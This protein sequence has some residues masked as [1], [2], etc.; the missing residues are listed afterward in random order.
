MTA[1]LRHFLLAVQFFTRIPITGRLALWVG[2]SQPMLNASAG[3]F[4]GV[5]W[6]VGVSAALVM[7]LALWLLPAGDLGALTA[8]I[9]STAASV[10]LTG[11]FHED[12]LSDTADGLGGAR[13]RDRALEI[14]KDSRIGNYGALALALALLLK[15]AL[16]AGLAARGS[17]AV[18]CALIAAHVLSR[19]APLVVMRSLPYVGAAQTSKSKPL[20]EAV[21]AASFRAGCLWSLPALVVLWFAHG[22]VHLVFALVLWGVMLFWF[23]RLL[24]RR[25]CGFTGDTLGATQQVCEL[26]LYLGLALA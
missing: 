13:G 18:A 14:M 9:L 26:A 11:G 10:W 1:A 12:G 17:A 19:F 25:L 21:S 2:Y 16:L 24:R 4:P 6:L 5:G 23:H 7:T 15:V 20:A 3:H 8:A 22:G